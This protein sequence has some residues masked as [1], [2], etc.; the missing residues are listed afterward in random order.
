M[1]FQKVD[2]SGEPK[3][4]L[5]TKNHLI[6]LDAEI[7]EEQEGMEAVLRD[8]IRDEFADDV[9]LLKEK[10]PQLYNELRSVVNNA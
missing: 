6:G 8:I 1:S 4:G 3:R 2:T 5:L 7:E 10:H 9:A